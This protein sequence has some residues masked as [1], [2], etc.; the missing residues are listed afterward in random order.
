[1]PNRA[2]ALL[3]LLL[4][5]AVPLLAA[6]KPA[7]RSVVVEAGT[8]RR[9]D[10]VVSFAVP[11]GETGPFRLR[12]GKKDVPLQISRGRGYFV[13][14]ALEAGATKTFTL[15]TVKEGKVTR[16]VEAKTEGE[17]VSFSHGTR[18]LLRYRGGRGEL[19]AG[20]TR[21]EYRRA[22]YIHPIFTPDGRMI[23]DDQPAD[24]RHHHGVWAAWT[25]TEID[26]R[27]PDFWNVG[28]KTG[29]VQF[30]SLDE[31]W[32]G[33]AFAGLRAKNRYIDLTAAAPTTALL[34]S[35]ELRVYPVL[36]ASGST[37]FDLELVQERTGTTPLILDEYRYGGVGFRGSEQWLPKANLACLTSEGK[38]RESGNGTPAR[39]VRVSG[40]VDGQPAAMVMYGHPS[41]FRAPQP[42]RLN[43][44]QPF[45][46]WA[47]PVAGR[48]EIKPGEP[49]VARYRFAAFG[50]VPDAAEIER[51]WNDYAEPP[52]VSVK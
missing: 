49:Y 9:Q 37:L 29:G 45:F 7:A 3:S 28:D 26:G 6:G 39:W 17:D 12:D 38:E 47:P 50:R 41:N 46:C 14:A 51:L 44:D 16:G 4:S 19:R 22:G 31:V 20:V 2:V 23:S 11:E 52:K 40:N 27:H 8:Q 32:S 34:E 1:M 24:H 36:G 33:A 43:P 5:P 48:F 21:E 13:V 18:T 25:K 15:D 10:V 35:W 30:E 42:M